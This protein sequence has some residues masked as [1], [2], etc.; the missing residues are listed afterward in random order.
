MKPVYRGM[1][2]LG[3]GHRSGR[4]ARRAAGALA[5]ALAAGTL[6]G[7]CAQL[8]APSEPQ[9]SQQT[10]QHVAHE[11]IGKRLKDVTSAL[12]PPT[13]VQYMQETGGQLIIYAHPGQKRYV[14]ETGPS[15]EIVSAT[16]TTP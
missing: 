14:F 12:G 13:T 16:E 10:E 9:P 6:L 4:A 2:Q 1:G 7:G 8:M 3:S 15:G 11:W 5:A